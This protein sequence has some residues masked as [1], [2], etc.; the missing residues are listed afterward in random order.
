MFESF[1]MNSS[2]E[3]QELYVVPACARLC[4][5]VCT[6]VFCVHSWVCVCKVVSLGVHG[7]V[8]ACASL[9]LKEGLPRRLGL[10][11]MLDNVVF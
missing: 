1:G 11:S 7:C 6:V 2:V 10:E 5:C 3:L 4:L 8:R 9:C